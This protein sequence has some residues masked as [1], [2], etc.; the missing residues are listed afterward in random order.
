MLNIPVELLNG[1]VTQIDM[2]YEAFIKLAILP[3]LKAFETALNKD[4]LTRKRKGVFLFC[5]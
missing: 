5:L 3:I 4:L 2:L 1:K